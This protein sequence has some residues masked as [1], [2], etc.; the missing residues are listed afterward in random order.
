MRICLDNSAFTLLLLKW[1]MP[2]ERRLYMYVK[3][4][5][6]KPKS[7]FIVAEYIDFFEVISYRGIREIRT[8]SK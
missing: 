5:E 2:Q 7:E 3:Y 6:N 1:T 4:C 8:E